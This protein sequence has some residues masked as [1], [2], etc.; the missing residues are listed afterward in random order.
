MKSK[1][2]RLKDK[3]WK[4]CSEYSRRKDANKNG[5]VK[6]VTCH[7]RKNWKELHAGHMVHGHYSESYLYHKNINPQCVS[8]NTFKSGNLDV[9]IEWFI[10]KHGIDEF[11]KIRKMKNTRWKWTEEKLIERIQFYEQKLFELD[12]PNCEIK[13]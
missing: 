7:T 3:A 11:Y 1:I 2:D 8:C 10:R 12:H 9:Y 6:C 4:L 5:T 13:D